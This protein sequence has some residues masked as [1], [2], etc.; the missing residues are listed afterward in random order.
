MQLFERPFGSRIQQTA[1]NPVSQCP[2]QHTL[3]SLGLSFDP[4][5]QWPLLY[6]RSATRPNSFIRRRRVSLSFSLPTSRK[7]PSSPC[8]MDHELSHWPAVDLGS[9]GTNGRRL[10]S[11]LVS[12]ACRWQWSWKRRCMLNGAAGKGSRREEEEHEVG[13]G[14]GAVST[15]VGGLWWNI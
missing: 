11:R 9:Y 12:I 15:K 14:L 13:W 3:C 8:A 10:S 7:T 6:S 2:T 4:S 1:H 5:N